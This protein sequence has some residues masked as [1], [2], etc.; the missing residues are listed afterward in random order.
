MFKLP[1][2]STEQSSIISSLKDHNVICD[3]VFGAGKTTL[4]LHISLSFPDLDILLLTYN[5][6]LKADTRKK[7][8]LLDIGNMEVHSYHS[9]CV[10]YYDKG[11]F[12]D[13]EID[14]I[15]REKK[16]P[17]GQ[18]YFN[19][20]IIDEAQDLTPLYYELVLKV[21]KEN[22]M[23]ASFCVVGD[24]FQSIFAF[25]HSDER[26]MINSDLLLPTDRKW[27]REILSISYRATRQ[28][29]SFLNKV[30]L[31]E[32]RIKTTGKDGPKVE[33]II[34]S[35]YE[36]EVHDRILSLLT[37]Y[38]PDEIFILAATVKASNNPKY[39]TPI[40]TLANKLTQQG[41]SV[42]VPSDDYQKVG[43]DDVLKGKVVFSTF[44][45]VKGLERRV[46]VV[47]GFDMSYFE[48]FKK[49]ANQEVV[50][51]ELYVAMTRSSETL[52][53]IHGKG[54]DFLPF[55]DMD[56]L[57]EESTFNGD[58][59]I[60][61]KKKKRKNNFKEESV[62]GI[63]RYLPFN[64]ISACFDFFS[65]KKLEEKGDLIDIP[66]MT[67]Q[68][69]TVEYVADL[70]ALA[71]VSFIEFKLTGRMTIANSINMFQE[72]NVG[73][74]KDIDLSIETEMTPKKLLAIAN[75]YMTSNS[76]FHFRL[77]QIKSYK[78]LTKSDMNR[79]LKR[80]NMISSNSIYELFLSKDIE[81][82]KRL[83]GLADCV[84][85]GVLY[86]FKCT[87]ELE[88]EHFVQLALYMY[89]AKVNQIEVNRFVLFNILTGESHEV[90]G[91][92]DRLEEMVKFLFS[93]K[94]GRQVTE[95]DEKFIGRLKEIRNKYE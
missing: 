23:R 45:Q 76:K 87:K 79:C 40:R 71:I 30:V 95:E 38:K 44:H 29:A 51:N 20:M 47:F 43:E 77:A 13:H 91:D 48:F 80:M 56:K 68:K 18:I 54:H 73:K 39:E 62:T 22:T 37:T 78:W 89:L 9:F 8:E 82:G 41:V 61:K 94:C 11:C 90:V 6:R 21:I 35:P 26:I 83:I 66:S 19:L 64:V 92:V 36:T 55:L 10:K 52:I 4:A 34:S 3:S 63:I 16:P 24:H 72:V 14:S 17:R 15:L 85:Q 93:H 57:Q 60:G 81:K 84:D 32:E 27:S 33:Y 58:L 31:G 88:K 67:K 59:I 53:L 70:N 46:V 86:E 5:K 12:T 42:Y 28:I 7:V 75:N 65:C 50:P 2:P 69:N 74:K 49:D 25:N 1:D